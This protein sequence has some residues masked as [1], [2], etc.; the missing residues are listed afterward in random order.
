M[1][2]YLTQH[3]SRAI[4]HSPNRIA[5][6]FG[7]R[8]RTYAELGERVARLASGL[9]SLGIEK[10]DRVGLLALNCDRYLEYFLAVFRIGAVANP[11]NTRWSEKEILFSLE[12]C[13][14]TVLLVD[15]TFRE[16][17]DRLR[18]VAP[19]L[20]RTLIYAGDEAVPS[21]MISYEALIANSAAIP[22]TT[23][24][25]DGDQLAG[26]FYTGGTT[27][28]PKGV[29]VTQNT[30]NASAAGRIMA[31][32]G[33]GAVSLHA[34]PLFHLAGG[35]GMWSALAVGGTHVFLPSFDPREAM[36]LI[37]R[38]RVNDTLIVPTMVQMILDH[39]EFHNFDLSSLEWVVYGAA[40][41][42]ETLLDRAVA[43]LPNIHFTQGYGMTEL[44]GG[45]VF[46]PPAYHTAEGRRAGKLKSAGRAG[47]LA[48]AKIVDSAGNEVCRGQV[49]EIAIRG[50]AVMLGYWNRPEETAETLRNGWVYSKDMAYMDDDGFIYIVDRLKDMIVSGGENVY[51]AE[52]EN[53]LM[54][55][56]TVSQCAVIGIPNERWGESVHAVVVRKPGV[57]L[58]ADTLIA[59]CKTLIA[60]YKCPRSVEFR[61]ALPLSAA[62]KILK[63]E[64]RAG[65]WK[66]APRQVN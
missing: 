42:S 10:G 37:E 28:F 38:E 58:D 39:P 55:H 27:G 5:T 59:H 13:E 41:I 46:L 52:V 11:V 14:T 23:S 15:D 9:R 29:M 18:A 44:S 32:S 63:H 8:K 16:M 66:G 35:L 40:P 48:E 12:D 64:L 22:Q 54:K 62:G 65:F 24:D 51:S 43:S 25:D 21:R 53:A 61:D 3:L 2:A 60:N 19:D 57:E 4:R 50:G 47:L 49:G 56:P 20:L 7:N 17:G 26:I 36:V 6:V 34:A 33:P 31:G 45:V 30:L 1:P